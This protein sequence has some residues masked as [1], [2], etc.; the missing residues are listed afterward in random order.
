MSDAKAAIYIH[1]AAI[2]TVN[3]AMLSLSLSLTHVSL[4]ILTSC[5]LGTL[6]ISFC[7]L[8]CVPI[9]FFSSADKITPNI[10]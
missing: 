10:L 2:L 6:Q 8:L 4:I 9:G 7:G 5:E 3:M 1:L